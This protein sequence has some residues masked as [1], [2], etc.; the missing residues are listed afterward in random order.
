MGT[1]IVS[2][3]NVSAYFTFADQPA[4]LVLFSLG[5]AGIVCGLIGYIIKHENKAFEEHK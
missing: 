1:S 5:V 3:E 4:A 2:W